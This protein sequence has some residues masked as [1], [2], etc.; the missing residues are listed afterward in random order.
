M[1]RESDITTYPTVA[2]HARKAEILALRSLILTAE[3]GLTERIKWN[4]PSYGR[5]DDRITMRLQPADRLELI[6]H[7][8]AKAVD[9][10]LAFT[11]ASGL[12]DWVAADRAVVRFAP[13]DVE[14]HSSALPA[15]VRAWIAAT[16]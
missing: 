14:R 2:N 9:T 6:F 12:L 1:S 16:A 13:G 10:P 4:A 3:P 5:P 11:D 15:L 8:G 7:R